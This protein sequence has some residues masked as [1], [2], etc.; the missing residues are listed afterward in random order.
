MPAWLVVLA[1]V[2]LVASP[3]VSAED[4]GFANASLAKPASDPDVSPFAKGDAIRVTV[5]TDTSSFVNGVYRIDDNGNVILPL[6]GR[7]R[8]TTMTTHEVSHMIDTTFARYLSFPDVRVEPLVR[9]AFIGGFY[10][11]GLYY[12][13]PELSFWDALAMSGGPQ[14][15]DGISRLRWERDGEVLSKDLIEEVTS[16]QSLSSMGF[17][18]GDQITVTTRPE[19]TAW[20]VFRNDVL[21]V[22]S[23]TISTVAT[24]ITLIGLLS[25]D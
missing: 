22:L 25:E 23:L 10:R 7:T 1:G 17:L 24:S 12:V 16:G 6:I 4:D 15:R 19:R 13:D 14:R 3:P 11:P 8:V 5:P 18:S 21:P 20:E 9:V 2:L